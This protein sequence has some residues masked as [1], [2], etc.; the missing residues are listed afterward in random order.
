M[1]PEVGF[2]PTTFRLRVGPKPSNWTR[3]GPSWLLRYGTDSIKTRPVPPGSNAWVA[4][5]V[6]T[7]LR[8]RSMAASLQRLEHPIA[9]GCSCPAGDRFTERLR[10][11]RHLGRGCRR[12]SPSRAVLCLPP[13]LYITRRAVAAFCPRAGAGT[14]GAWSV[15]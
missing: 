7:M 3:P 8:E 5:E 14:W 10:R 11:R 1:E 15:S 12:L 2:E 9:I 4:R 13:P 6:A